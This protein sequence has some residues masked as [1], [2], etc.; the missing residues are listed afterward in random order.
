[1]ER[2]SLFKAGKDVS[3]SAIY[4]LF[5]NR[6][7]REVLLH[8]IGNDFG[9]GQWRGNINDFYR[10]FSPVTADDFIVIYD[11]LLA[12]FNA[13]IKPIEDIANS[14]RASSFSSQLLEVIESCKDD[15]DLHEK[16]KS[17]TRSINGDPVVVPESIVSNTRIFSSV[18]NNYTPVSAQ[19]ITRPDR[20]K[21]N[22]IKEAMDRYK[23]KIG[24]SYVYQYAYKDGKESLSKEPPTATGA[25]A[26]EEMKSA[27]ISAVTKNPFHF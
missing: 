25:S 3:N 24:Y 15:K 23:E 22:G 7:G 17:L 2:G 14:L 19:D 21:I 10:S 16:V 4:V 1:M 20:S 18:M 12:R 5:E 9:G 6:N 27:Y 11:M 26:D 13:Y 8:P